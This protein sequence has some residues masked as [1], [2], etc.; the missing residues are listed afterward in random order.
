MLTLFD[1]VKETGLGAGGEVAS[2]RADWT[3]PT[4]LIP[5]A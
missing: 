5:H 2:H 1:G 4:R 3:Y